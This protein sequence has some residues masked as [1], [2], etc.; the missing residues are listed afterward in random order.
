VPSETTDQQK[1]LT[2]LITNIAFAFRSGTEIVVDQLARGL[3]QRGHRPIV[4]ST[5][6]KGAMADALRQQGIAVV[7]RL[8]QVGA[9]PDIIHGQH[10]VTT[11]MAMMAFPQCPVVFSCHDFEAAKDRAPLV[12]RIRRY[13]AVDEICRER[14]S[15]DGVPDAQ[16]VMLYN[17]LDLKQFQRRDPLPPRPRNVLVL[18][19][20][21]DHL[22]VVRSAVERA[23]LTLDGLGSGVDTVVDDLPQ[24][25]PRYDIVIATARMAKEAMAVGCAVIVGDHRGFAG[26]VTRDVVAEWR[27]HNFGRKIL[28]T[29]MT[30]DDL[31]GA[32]AGY[33]A[34]DAAAVTDFIRAE[35]GLDRHLDHLERLYREV[36]A[37][38]NK[39]DVAEDMKALSVFLEDFLISR[40]FTRPW[41]D[42][43]RNV[44]Q[45]ETDVLERTLDRHGAKMQVTIM[46]RLDQIERTLQNNAQSQ[47][48]DVRD[49][50]ASMRLTAQLRSLIG[51]LRRRLHRLMGAAD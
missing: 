19:K 12:P 9:V 30:Q 49:L 39:V 15:N 28:T 18:T 50:G 10:N 41:A 23:G 31:L 16:I 8:A 7:D 5:Y 13:I 40:D 4:F 33:D 27:R 47:A 6:I 51:G 42:L 29:P 14:L 45:E 46:A 32:I 2:V 36:I 20:G 11:V 25:L 3:N 26:L 17:A 37:E 1:S 34:A 22:A 43:Y 35:D 38:G 48:R 21:A 24:R 44:V